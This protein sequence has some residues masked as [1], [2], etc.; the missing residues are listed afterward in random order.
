MSDN[1]AIPIH[2]G[3]VL[4]GNRRWAKQNGLPVVQ[5]H[6]H[7]MDVL[8]DISF[9]AF[10]RGVKYLSA[11]VF[12][13]ENWQRAEEEVNYLMDLTVKAVEKY[14]D[15]F[16][17]R[18]IKVIIMGRRSGVRQKV[19]DAIDRTEE[20]TKDNTGGTLVL[21][22]NYG[23]REELVDAVQNIVA[24]GHSASDVT[25]DTL[26]SSLYRPEIPDID[27]L[28]RTS[29]EQRTSGFML[30]RAAYAELKFLDKLWPDFTT[31]DFDD[32]M[33]DYVNRE[34]RFGS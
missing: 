33:K 24:E 7:G 28:I 16:H 9:H 13:T 5:G 15:E 31:T 6:R 30:Y 18:G 32:C 3:L 20:K 11:F 26:W 8:K 23:G 2:M 17:E 22:F 25:L 1:A 27:L 19:L 29:G 34:R 14:L 21:C 4:D 12:S 10:E